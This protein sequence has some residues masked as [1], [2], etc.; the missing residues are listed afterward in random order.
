MNNT[1][2]K[3]R[4]VGN[5]EG[6]LYYSKALNC[7]VFDY[8]NEIGKRRREK[9]RKKESVKDFKARIT[10]LKNELNNGTY[11]GKST[12]TVISLIEQHINTKH[13]DGITSARSYRRELETLNQ[14]KKTCSN[15]CNKPIQN[16]TINDI[17]KAKENIKVYS[18]STITKI[19]EK[20]NKAF[21]I[22]YSP[23]RKILSVNI[24]NDIDLKK[25]LSNKV[26]QK[27]KALT[28]HEHQ[29]LIRILD[30]EE[31]NHKYRNL[32]RMQDISGMRIGEVIARSIND[33]DT[34]THK[35]NVHNTITQDQNYN[36]ILGK[37]TKTYNKKTQI[38]EGQRYLPLDYPLFSG[39]LEIIEEQK[40][41]KIANINNLLFWDYEKNNFI[42]P[43]EINS[44]LERLN[45]KY[46]ICNDSLTT[47]RLRHTAITH[48]RNIG[49]PLSVIQ[50][51]AGHVEGSKIT[52]ETYID[53]SLEYVENEL[54]KII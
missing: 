36:I 35:F 40:N 29:R 48:W 50:Y 26:T 53:T 24:M 44:W 21:T 47:H 25:P 42:S 18:N 49:V 11:V 33:L 31:R 20:L 17:E 19:W 9:Q 14:I 41:N 13:N 46:H 39:L 5:G 54:K 8:F 15:F 38:D 7:W 1:N 2:K 32:V 37:H 28:E 45:K 34:E 6:S 22:A 10:K 16:V 27:V 51:L 4:T 30:N 12:E 23:S 52:E 3:T 43:N